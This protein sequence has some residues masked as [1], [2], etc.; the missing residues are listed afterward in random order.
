M[1]VSVSNGFPRSKNII[2]S[3]KFPEISQKCS[4]KRVGTKECRNN[5]QWRKVIPKV[6]NWCSQ[7]IFME[8]FLDS[9]TLDWKE[10]TKPN[11]TQKWTAAEKQQKFVSRQ[12]WHGGI[13]VVVAEV[14][15][16]SVVQA[17]GDGVTKVIRTRN[18]NGTRH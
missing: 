16:G 9:Q 10:R 3:K 17:C 18:S 8:G 4:G 2:A 12:E 14:C 7:K 13:Y 5:G 6:E 15:G 11:T 1:M